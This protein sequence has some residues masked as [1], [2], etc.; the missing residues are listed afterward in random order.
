MCFI[1]RMFADGAHEF[2]VTSDDRYWPVA[3]LGDMKA[4]VRGITS[5]DGISIR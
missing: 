3:V 1:Q 2:L 4:D 5:G